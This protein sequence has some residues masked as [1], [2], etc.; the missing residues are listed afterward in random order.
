M[1]ENYLPSIKSTMSILFLLII[2]S[3]Y[4]HSQVP[5][6]IPKPHDPVDL[7][8]PFNIILYFGGF[9]LMLIIFI[10]WRIYNRRKKENSKNND[11]F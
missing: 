7:T 1:K 3:S 4:V 5:R 8:S 11:D 9:V 10:F 2:N 6:E